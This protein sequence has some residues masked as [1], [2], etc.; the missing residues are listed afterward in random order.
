MGLL[1]NSK[2]IIMIQIQTT[3]EHNLEKIARI[4]VVESTQIQITM[5]ERVVSTQL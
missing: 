1:V 2:K 4:K 3:V 5:I